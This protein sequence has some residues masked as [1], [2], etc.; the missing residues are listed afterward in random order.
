M[1]WVSVGPARSGSNEQRRGIR[2]RCS[3]S[4]VVQGEVLDRRNG[5]DKVAC[6]GGAEMASDGPSCALND[7]VSAT[8]GS[9]RAD[10]TRLPP[11]RLLAIDRIRLIIDCSGGIGGRAAG[12]RYPAVCRRR[13]LPARR[14]GLIS[15]HVRGAEARTRRRELTASSVRSASS[16]RGRSVADNGRTTRGAVSRPIG[17]P[18]S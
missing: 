7:F 8:N 4:D 1:S 15:V 12:Q 10:T 5:C 11:D 9:R 13:N 17:N 3:H 2:D 6:I 16:S 14:N 18:S